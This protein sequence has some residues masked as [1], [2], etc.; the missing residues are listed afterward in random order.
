MAAPAEPWMDEDWH[1][2]YP[3]E[4]LGAHHLRGRDVPL[5]IARIERAE[6]EL[7]KSGRKEK[8][9]RVV[10]WFKELAGRGPDLPDKW[11]CNRTCAE[12]IGLMHGKPMRGWVGKRITLY[13]EPGTFFGK[14]GEAIRVRPTIPQERS[15]R[16]RDPSPPSPT[17]PAGDAPLSAAGEAPLSEEEKR[18]ILR[19][20]AEEQR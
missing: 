2:A 15:Q 8:K 5:T 14:K 4:Y 11:I 9:K 13:G 10:I 12:V 1:L 6:L 16:A 19:R 3:S 18:E 20:E 7:V 17:S